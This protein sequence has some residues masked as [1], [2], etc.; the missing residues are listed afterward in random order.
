MFRLQ[1][2]K[3]LCVILYFFDVFISCQKCQDTLQLNI[4]VKYCMSTLSRQ[5]IK[6]NNDLN[7]MYVDTVDTQEE[8]YAKLDYI[9]LFI[10]YVDTVYTMS[11]EYTRFNGTYVDT[12]DMIELQCKS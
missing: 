9:C 12:V 2:N 3:F 7:A 5:E 6:A 11:T 4:C 8:K 1:I 10:Y